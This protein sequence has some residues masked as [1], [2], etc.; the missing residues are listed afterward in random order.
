MVICKLQV[1]DLPRYQTVFQIAD[2]FEAKLGQFLSGI[3]RT[4]IIDKLRPNGC[5]DNLSNA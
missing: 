3:K 2:L 5:R 4:V 1:N